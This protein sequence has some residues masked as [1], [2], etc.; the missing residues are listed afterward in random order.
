VVQALLAQG[1]D[2]QACARDGATALTLAARQGHAAVVLA[3]CAAQ[4]VP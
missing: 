3:L 1:A 2:T 4:S